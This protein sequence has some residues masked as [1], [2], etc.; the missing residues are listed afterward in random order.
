MCHAQARTAEDTDWAQIAALYEALARLLPTPVVAAQPGGG[1]SGWRTG[2]RPG[3]TLADAL[4]DRARAA[5]TTTCCPA[6]GATCWPGWAEREEARLEFERAAALTGN[7]AERA[8]LRRAGGGDP[9]RP[10]GIDPRRGRAGLPAPRRSGRRDGPLLRPDPAPA[11]PQPGR[12]AAAGRADRRPGRAGVRDGLGTGGGRD[13]EPAP[14]GRPLVR[15]LGVA[16]DDL[17]AGLDRACRDRVPGPSR[18]EPGRTSRR[19]GAAPTCRCA[20]ARCGGCC[21]SRRAGVTAVLVARTSRTW[22]WTT[23]GPAPGADLGELARR[24]PPGCC[25]ELVAGRTRGPVFLADRRPGPGRRPA[26]AD[27]CPETGRA[28]PVLRAGRVPV[29]AG[30]RRHLADA[31]G[32]RSLSCGGM[33]ICQASVTSS[34]SR[35]TSTCSSRTIT[36]GRPS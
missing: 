31:Q 5:A 26:P 18:I 9:G 1:A 22:T 15:R 4:V 24:R 36:N 23:A 11:V 14:G 28:P 10:R 33:R 19:S 30:H 20:N 6:S 21:T 29:Q 27:L 35:T 3:S 25:R 16:L 2:R 8:F 12:A 34:V 13:V 7:A 17:A 32:R